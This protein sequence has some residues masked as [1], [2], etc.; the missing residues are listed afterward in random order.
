MH[1]GQLQSTCH[2][3]RRDSRRPLVGYAEMREMEKRE[4]DRWKM[5]YAGM[6]PKK[7]GAMTSLFA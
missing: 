1:M 3:L 5:N 6:P 4:R 7:K 2:R